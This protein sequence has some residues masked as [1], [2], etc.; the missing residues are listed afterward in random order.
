MRKG[1]PVFWILLLL[2]AAVALAQKKPVKTPTGLQ[3]IDHV[4][5]KG[6]EAKPGDKVKVHYTGWLYEKGARGSKFDSSKDR[7]KPF[8][9]TIGAGTVIKGWE[10]GVKG[11]K[12]GGKREL[13]VP[14]SLAYGPR[15]RT[16][17]PPNATLDFEIELLGIAQK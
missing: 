6:Q 16:G 3:Y 14:A 8:M 13:I 15:G 11:M 7:D 12:I 1:L 2:M 17:I 9:F 4:V 5:G 10:E